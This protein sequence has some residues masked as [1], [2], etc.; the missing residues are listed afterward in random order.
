MQSKTIN[1]KSSDAQPLNTLTVYGM[2]MPVIDEHLQKATKKAGI[3]DWQKKDV[4]FD[5]LALP[6]ALSDV[7]SIDKVDILT[8]WD[9]EARCFIIVVTFHRSEHIHSEYITKLYYKV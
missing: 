4:D 2:L 5:C 6:R 8:N 1:I 3:A 7:W 9:S